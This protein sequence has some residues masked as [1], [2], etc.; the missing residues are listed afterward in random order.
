ME[1]SQAIVELRR[2]DRAA[3]KL[4]RIRGDRITEEPRG[5]RGRPRPQTRR[6]VRR[7]EWN[8]EEPRGRQDRSSRACTLGRARRDQL[9]I[10]NSIWGGHPANTIFT[11]LHFAST[12]A[13]P[14]SL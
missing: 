11:V 1:G 5:T 6:E 7:T 4:R 2:S 13:H 14:R 8:R 10:R 3:E 9:K 12:A